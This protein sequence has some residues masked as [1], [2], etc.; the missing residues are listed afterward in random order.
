MTAI[1]YRQRVEESSQVGEAR[2]RAEALGR[3]LNFDEERNGNVAIVVTELATNLLKHAARGELILRALHEGD[4]S[5]LEILSLDQGAGIANLGESLRDGHSTVGSAGTGLGSV[6]RLSTV[7]DIYSQA[8]QGTAIL[9]HIW[10]PRLP[11][12][13]LQLWPEIGV[14][15]LPVSGEESCGDAWALHQTP[16]RTLV[17]LADG[18]GHGLFAAEA[19]AEA[20]HIFDKFSHLTPTE[21]MERMHAAL[22]STRGAVVA[23]A[24]VI[25]SQH[26]VRYIGVGNIA[27]RILT[28]AALRSMVSHNGTVGMEARK[29][30]EFT[31]AMPDDGLLVL[32]TDGL[33]AHWNLDDYPGLQGRHS[34]LLAGVLFR[35]FHRTRDDNA[36]IVIRQAR[37]QP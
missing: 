24:E 6:Q 18:L 14:I 28:S 19:S 25:W 12:M 7:F 36:V 22:R 10:S 20:V 37:R 13:P 23:I 32:H 15:C 16:G 30:Q 35:D 1:S 5:G 26:L 9:S 4:H 34:A 27:G 8:G 31:Y 17:M 33:T 3:S 29:F 2:R 21:I 11:E